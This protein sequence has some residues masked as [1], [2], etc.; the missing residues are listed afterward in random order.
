[1]RFR[2]RRFRVPALAACATLAAPAAGAHATTVEVVDAQGR[3]QVAA[4]TA[5][6]GERWWTGPDG[7]AD[8][9]GAPALTVSRAPGDG[10]GGVE[11]VAL[12]PGLATAKVVVAPLVR[13]GS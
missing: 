1:M 12:N 13:A 8:V 9:P 11:G 4:L 7:R 6:T 5:P 10:C 3:P 2:F